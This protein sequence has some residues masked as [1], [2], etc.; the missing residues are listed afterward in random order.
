MA[1]VRIGFGSDFVVQ[2]ESVGIKTDTPGANL[3]VFGD[4]KS[5]SASIVGVSTFTSYTGFVDKTHKLG[6]STVDL[7]SQQHSLSGD[8]IIEGDLTVSSGTTFTS[9]PENL[10]VT[11]DFTLPMGGTENREKNPTA[12]TTRFN[13]NLAA[14][15]FYTGV[16]W[17]AVNSYVDSGNRGRA[18]FMGGT[19]NYPNGTET[20][21]IDMVQIHTLGNA[22]NFG[23]LT[24]AQ[25]QITCCSSSIRG[26][27]MGGNRPATD[28][29]DYITI[30]AEG[31]AIDFG[32][33]SANRYGCGGC[34][35]STRGFTCG[36]YTPADLNT[37]EYIE[38]P[39]LGNAADFGDLTYA[40]RYGS[41]FS[42]P[43]RAYTT[44][45]SGST[46]RMIDV[47]IMASK[48]NATNYGE[49]G[50][51]A[52]QLTGF[53]NVVRG[54]YLVDQS[55]VGVGLEHIDLTSSGAATDFGSL[56]RMT[57]AELAQ[58][59]THTRGVVAGGFNSPAITSVNNIEYISIQ[60][61]GDAVDFGD[62]TQVTALFK[63][64][65]DSH[66]GLGGF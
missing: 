29:M 22:V 55:S 39:T 2:N 64:C 14:L 46:S 33:L 8:I 45:G 57:G 17:K 10:T 7:N 66:G 24:S 60:S 42:S 28:T 44:G 23:S 5:T 52:A 54:I 59:S 35:S 40:R 12:G 9:G 20:D 21:K 32:N 36:G 13:E 63:G 50:A 11:D 56:G 43:V 16:E 48:G 19:L 62:L 41:S 26:V 38:I 15:E 25:D 65:S 51:S 49:T 18:V 1:K 4:I 30:A 3:H 6:T 37:I 27:R 61:L 47:F 53:S 34:S 31:N 58:G